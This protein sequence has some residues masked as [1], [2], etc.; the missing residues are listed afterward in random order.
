M[1]SFLGMNS[2]AEKFPERLTI[3]AFPSNQF[4][5]QENGGNWRQDLEEQEIIS[6][7]EH[8]RPGG[9][10]KTSATLMKKGDVNGENEL[11]IF[12]WLK[13]YLPVP[14]G[15]GPAT[16]DLLM[17]DPKLIIWRPVKRSDIAWNFEKFLITPNGQPFLRY[18]RR[19]SYQVIEADIR[20]L[21]SSGLGGGAK[22]LTIGSR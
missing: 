22:D 5:H 7:L 4:G 16:E 19:A 13:R 2:L 21:L 17:D 12:T 8:V 18:G 15:G 10:F 6:A 11:P 14:Q 9:G 3:L 20:T 1:V